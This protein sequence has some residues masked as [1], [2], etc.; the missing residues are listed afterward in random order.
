M[1][2]SL[3]SFRYVIES[4]IP[5]VLEYLIDVQIILFLL[6]SVTA[7]ILLQLKLYGIERLGFVAIKGLGPSRQ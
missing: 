3:L 5:F 6:F 1:M 7:T 2:I 4:D